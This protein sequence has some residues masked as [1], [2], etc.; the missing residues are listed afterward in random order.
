MYESAADTHV[1]C[2]TNAVSYAEVG[3]QQAWV[4]DSACGVQYAGNVLVYGAMSPCDGDWFGGVNKANA[5]DFLTAVIN[6]EVSRLPA[7]W[8][9]ICALHMPLLHRMQ[10]TACIMILKMGAMQNSSMPNLPYLEETRL[11]CLAAGCNCQKATAACLQKRNNL[12][13]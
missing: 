13:V 7:V 1:W 11:R 10:S 4:S 12:H 5:A 9:P 2:M 8:K 6:A 3:L